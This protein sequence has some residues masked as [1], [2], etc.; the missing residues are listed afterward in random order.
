MCVVFHSHPCGS[1]WLSSP[2]RL[3][4]GIQPSMWLHLCPHLRVSTVEM[5]WLFWESV[6]LYDTVWPEFKLWCGVGT[7]K[8]LQQGCM[9]GCAEAAFSHSGAALS[10]TSP[11]QLWCVASL[12]PPPPP[13]FP[14]TFREPNKTQVFSF[15]QT[16]L[17]GF[18][19]R[20]VVDSFFPS[21][22]AEFYSNLAKAVKSLKDHWCHECRSCMVRP[23][24]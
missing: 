8:V 2:V 15:F 9:L 19:P 20:S 3:R 21:S 7:C 12:S 5:Y 17:G 22:M 1:P 13:F 24:V 14:P 23:N 10:Q 4:Q 11:Q 18:L 6:C 16:D